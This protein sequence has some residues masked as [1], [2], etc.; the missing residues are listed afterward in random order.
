MKSILQ[1]ALAN[2]S[3]D[4]KMKVVSF[5]QQAISLFIVLG[6][7]LTAVAG[8][9]YRTDMLERMAI[10]MKITMQLDTLKDGEYY[11]HLYY[12]RRPIT[13]IVEK[14]EIVHLGYSVFTP[15]IRRAMNSPVCNFLERYALGI[16][17]PLKREKSIARQLDEDGVFFRGGDFGTFRQLEN[18]TSYVVGLE[19][20]NGKRY[21]VSWQKDGQTRL[22]INFPIEHD[23]LAG[24]EVLEN[25]R[26][27]VGC[28]QRSSD[29]CRTQQLA[30]STRLK[31]TW[32]GK[33]FILPGDFYYMKQLN[34]NRYYEKTDKGNY[35]LFFH[36]GYVLESLSNLMT[37]A[38]IENDYDMEI[39]QVKY[40]FAQDTVKVKL[41]QWLNFC[42]EEGCK[43]YF[44]IIGIDKDIADCELVMMN[45][46]MGYL[47]LM[48]MA[49]DIT[50]L[51]DRRGLI[52]ARLNSYITTTR[53]K[54]LFGELK[55]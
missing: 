38:T 21:T 48:R 28:I 13:V 45:P 11:R 20:L 5:A 3:Q 4:C 29:T 17:L 53:V 19:N 14:G 22:S 51:D 52:K 54:Y 8:N 12:N 23:L 47:H 27:I 43:G 30:D 1:M 18:D 42:L 41:N 2:I 34:S 9:S 10:A 37:T 6:A 40:G 16:T 44:G 15:N 55:M 32:Q 7:C 46:T 50:T 35:R 36:P 39:R 25:E 49:I 31:L 24:T 26:R 33:Y